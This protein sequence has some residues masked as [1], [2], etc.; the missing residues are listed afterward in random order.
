LILAGAQGAFLPPKEKASLEADLQAE[1][2]RI[3]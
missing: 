1:L 2:L 3:P